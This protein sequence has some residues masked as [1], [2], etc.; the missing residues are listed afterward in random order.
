[1]ALNFIVRLSRLAAVFILLGSTLAD[2][3]TAAADPSTADVASVDT[4][5]N[6]RF[7]IHGQA[8]FVTQGNFAFR[9]PYDGPN[10][11]DGNGDLRET[12]DVTAYF[13]ASPW[14]GGELWANPEIDQG[15]GLRN[16]LGAAGFPS[17][18]AYKVGRANPYFRM[19][20]LFFRQTIDLGGLTQS[21]GADLNQ[22]AG[23]RAAD[24]LVLTVGKL[25]V[26]DIFDTNLY[27]HDPRHDFLNWTSVDAG[28]FDYAADAWGYSYGA[29]A[30]L[31]LGDLTWRGGLFNL[32]K[33]PNDT[34]LE[35]GFRQYQIDA[36]IEHR[37]TIG[38]HAGAIRI[39][40]FLSHGNMARLDDAVAY[41]QANGLPV[42]PVPVR[43][44]A[45]RTGLYVNAEQELTTNIGAFLRFSIADGH[46]E[47]YEFTDADRSLSLG[48]A[49]KGAGY[50]RPTDTIGV[51]LIANGISKARQRYLSAGGLGIL[52]GDGQLL[53]PGGEHIAETYYDVA[54]IGPLHA[55]VDGQLILNPAYNRQ[56]GPVPVLA[57]R[58]HVQF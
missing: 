29:A 57:G 54:I 32:S 39:G 58:L 2:P 24:R 17:A 21:V 7:A 48:V 12:F 42:S 38:G 35:T 22:L 14:R 27:A 25:G 23:S 45:S 30:E 18:E 33:L 51:A 20:R 55:A 6:Q 37:H 34:V 56:R 28:A 15:F 9:A 31:T 49:I 3:A 4:I 47:S 50:G 43:H 36:E 44:F 5:A 10:S 16:T 11:L 8:T 13:G 41:G 46:Y 1:M 52:V 19:Q 53:Q 40:G 26:V